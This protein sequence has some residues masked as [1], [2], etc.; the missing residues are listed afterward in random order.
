MEVSC[1]SAIFIQFPQNHGMRFVLPLWN[2]PIT[3][4]FI[5]WL[6]ISP[7]NLSETVHNLSQK[8]DLKMI[9]GPCICTIT[10]YRLEHRPRHHW[11]VAHLRSNIVSS[12]PNTSHTLLTALPCSTLYQLKINQHSPTSCLNPNLFKVLITTHHRPVC[13]LYSAISLLE[14]WKMIHVN[15]LLNDLPLYVIQFSVDICFFFNYCLV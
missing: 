7:Y 2:V 3:N 9:F 6:D 8:F 14:Y 15:D 11:A 13:V 5:H 4:L 10:K 12:W 1:S